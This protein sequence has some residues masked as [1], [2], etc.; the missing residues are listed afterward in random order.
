VVALLALFALPPLY[1]H[2]TAGAALYNGDEA[3]Y[4]EMA[5]EMVASGRPSEL[6]FDGEVVFPRPPASVWPI[7]AWYAVR[8]DDPPEPAV[9]A[10][11]A[12]LCA[13]AVALTIALGD[14]L[15]GALT[16]VLAGG[17]LAFSDLLVGYARV[18][19]S[20]P[21]LLCFVLLALYG[22]A[23][24]STAGWV[25]FGL[26]LGGALLTKQGVGLLPLIGPI[27]DRLSPAPR[28]PSRGLVI[29]LAIGLAIALPWHLVMLHRHGGAFAEAFFLRS[30]LGRGS[31][32]LLRRT[33]PWFYLRE[34]LRSEGW[35]F[36][37]LFLG[38]ALA[39][40]AVGLRRGRRAELMIGAWAIIVLV[41]YSLARSR[42]DYYLLLCYP[43]F[44]IAAAWAIAAFPH[45]HGRSA[46]AIAIVAIAA[47]DHLPRN[48][49][50]Q[51]GDEDTRAIFEHARAP[52][53]ARIYTLGLHPYTARV[54]GGRSVRV[55]VESERDL[56]AART[57]RAT[58]MPAPAILADPPARAF[59][60]I[61][62][63]ALLLY[64]RAHLHA[65]DEV[66]PE[67]YRVIADTQR[68]RLLLLP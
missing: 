55:F 50:P 46:L 8:G 16:G 51:S 17:L 29:G 25:L 47:L 52:V 37:T 49:V 42:Y 65:L 2:G 39:S 27:S 54:Y 63:P 9:R 36:A 59:E 64:P 43:A 31:V 44:A 23:R 28:V 38:G 66:A 62:R 32:S 21:L 4:A 61:R 57:V 24:R 56:V 60:L 10:V 12:F 67:R 45:R 13:L 53:G 48:L 15:Y 41:V 11:N 68:L 18:Y 7:A 26:G 22:W 33:S 3:I 20:E 14:A 6:R 30:L 40:L 5:R 34:L 35:F 58:G 19:E 1:R